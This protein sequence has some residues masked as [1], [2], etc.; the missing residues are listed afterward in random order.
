MTESRVPALEIAGL[1]AM[2]F[3]LRMLVAVLTPVPA[4]DAANYLWMAQRFAAGDWAAALSEVFP[5][6][7]PLLVA[8]VVAAGFD[9]F[10]G[11]QLVVASVAALAIWPCVRLAETREPS[12]ARITGVLLALLPLATRFVGEVLTEPVFATFAATALLAALRGH[13]A[14]S[15]VAAALAFTLRPE[16]LALPAAN[17]V[18]GRVRGLAAVLPLGAGVVGLAAWRSAHGQAFE[19]LPKLGF[20]AARGDAALSADGIRWQT[21]LEN[22]V[23]LPGAWLEAFWGV[24]LL[25]LYGIWRLRGDRTGRA[26]VAVL[27]VVVMAVLAFLTRRRFLVAWFP[28]LALFLP[29]ALAALRERSRYVLQVLLV[30]TSLLGCLNF[31]DDDRYGERVVGEWLA[32]MLRPGETVAGDMTRVI[33]FAGLRPLSPRHFSTEELREA[34]RAA[35]VRFVVLGGRRAG[36]AELAASLAPGFTPTGMP[37]RETRAAERR[38]LLVLERR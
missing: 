20:N 35:G 29:V 14:W 18:L 10:R 3:A 30:L 25:A 1:C 2:A 37:L 7:L 21:V 12:L 15:G 33:W 16:A 31:T 11:G 23:A 9:P 28:V 36:N 4:E 38:G 32:T 6:G 27:A 5:P 8:P 26:F 34:T 19:L 13:H 24:G 17:L 22:L